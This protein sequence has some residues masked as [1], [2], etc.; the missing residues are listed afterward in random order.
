MGIGLS[1]VHP[2]KVYALIFRRGQ[3]QI[4]RVR[5]QK[6]GRYPPVADKVILLPQPSGDIIVT[7]PSKSSKKEKEERFKPSKTTLSLRRG[8]QQIACPITF[9][10][11]NLGGETYFEHE[12]VVISPQYR[13]SERN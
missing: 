3:L 5:R 9:V 8:K 12:F 1:V 7:C 4:S 10:S 2:N 6:N 11:F 13:L